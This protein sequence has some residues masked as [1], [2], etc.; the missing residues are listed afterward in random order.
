MQL[1]LFDM[2]TDVEVTPRMLTVR[3]PW[4]WAI[5]HAGK[6]V[7]NRTWYTDHRGPLLIVAGRKIDPEGYRFLAAL[8]IEVPD[9]SEQVGMVAGL[10]Q[11]ADCV[12]GDRSPWAFPGAEMWHWQVREA[13]AATKRFEARGTL[14]LPFAPDGWQAAFA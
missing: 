4:A 2:P 11:V 10:V 3:Q 14:G 5:I 7:E 13:E 12:R 1:G 8:G 9:L 6:D